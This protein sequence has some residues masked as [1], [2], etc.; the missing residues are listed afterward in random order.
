MPDIAIIGGGLCGLSL[1][2][3]LHRQG[4][5]VAV[6]EARDRL[7]GRILSIPAETSG[8][9]L[10]LGA[11][12]IWAASQPRL[13]RMVASLGL[14]TFTQHDPGDALFL[15]QADEAPVARQAPGIHNG[16]QRLER[17]MGALVNALAAR[18]PETAFHP[19]HR[20]VSAHDEGDGV[21]LTFET[22]DGSHDVRANLAILAAPPR[23][24]AETVAFTPPLQAHVREAMQ[25]TGTWMASQAKVMVAYDAPV[26]R[27][28]GRSGNAFVT[29]D[30][31]VLGEVFD[32]SDRKG[33]AAALGGFL[34]LG[35][36]A[37][38]AFETGLPML[39]ESQLEQLFGPSLG[40]GEQHLVD[41]AKDGCACSS[42]DLSDP[43][44]PAQAPIANPYLRRALWQGRL[45]LGGSETAAAGAG[46]LEGALDAAARINRQIQASEEAQEAASPL[47]SAPS[48][49]NGASLAAFNTVV[50]D[51]SANAF[52]GYRQRLIRRLSNQEREQLTQRAVLETFED[53]FRKSLD[54]LRG[55][56]FE[57]EDVSVE[58]G[59]CAYTPLVQAPFRGLM[60][61]LLDDVIAFNQTSCALS[62]FPDEHDLP[63]DYW[64]TILR[65]VAAAWREFSLHANQ[66][67]LDKSELSRKG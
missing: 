38:E 60:Q 41:W 52:D 23:L 54:N 29:H 25:E 8:L 50:A 4:R 12:W 24:I 61:S 15:E 18:I 37:R 5:D 62:N 13:A 7:G 36:Q 27:A 32:A 53:V 44:Q 59:R 28:E 2:E 65:D 10:D 22:A 42:R 51:L 67:L 58:N 49:V 64:Q 9:M 30:Q 33:E 57:M 19:R 11:S 16:A 47:S 40:K 56:D 55:L 26:W 21:V 20:L 63:R 14:S 39:I 34:A 31:A 43:R 1:A 46:Y 66:T 17:G 6:Y 45:Y 48:S 35:P 3:T